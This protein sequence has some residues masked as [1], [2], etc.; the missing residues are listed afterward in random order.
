MEL[1]NKKIREFTVQV[2]EKKEVMAEAQ[3]A[4]DERQ[5]DL[6]GKKVGT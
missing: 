4:L 2:A 5:R 6:D 3:A 1:C